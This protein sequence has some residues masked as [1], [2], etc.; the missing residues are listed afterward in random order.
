MTPHEPPDEHVILTVGVFHQ[1]DL[2]RI[3]VL[4]LP[5]MTNQHLCPDSYLWF[6]LED[7]QVLF[8][9]V[10]WICLDIIGN[11]KLD[12]AKP[13]AAENIVAKAVCDGAIDVIWDHFNGWMVSKGT[14]D[15]NFPIEL[16]TAFNSHI[17]LCMNTPN[18]AV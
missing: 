13:I 16:Q 15:V 8:R 18:E 5:G 6:T 2:L 1:A 7:L 14:G 4:F 17:A 12:Y 10:I 11:L 9:W 3:G